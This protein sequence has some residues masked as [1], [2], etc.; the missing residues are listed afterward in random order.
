MKPGFLTTEFWLALAPVFF[1]IGEFLKQ[2]PTNM[3]DAITRVAAIVAIG[4]ASLG[5]S[6]SRGKAKSA[7]LMSGNSRR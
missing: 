3:S 5:Y 4:V 2:P 7:D 1:A 6:S